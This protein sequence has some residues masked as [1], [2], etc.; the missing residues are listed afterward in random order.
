MA[1]KKKC[2][3]PEGVP[4]WVV[5]YGDMMSLLLTFF[6]LLAA[7]SEIR[8][9]RIEP[10][11]HAIKQALGV[12]TGQGDV[13]IDATPLQSVIENMLEVAL[14]REKIP[15]RSNAEDPGVDG[16]EVTVKRIREG[17]QF[18]VGGL[19]T[20][21]A[22]SADLK[23]Q[24]REGLD[25]VIAVVRG[26]NNKIEVR[27]HADGS[28]LPPGA[29]PGHLWDLSYRRARAVMDYLTDPA[30]GIDPRRIRIT[31]CGDKEPL[32]SRAYDATQSA[33]NRRVEIIV[34]E[35][36]VQQFEATVQAE[37]VSFVDEN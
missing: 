12:V 17:L 4:E 32:A 16:R 8:K 34:T 36:L 27:G 30:R 9:E 6:I 24:G 21:E 5:T 15:T 11:V 25:R 3:C 1:D 33:V 29:G 35:S 31:G 7:F 23:P 19:I 14:H 22:D 26:Q 18:T 13:P 28:D 10:V 37:A 20:F 2:K